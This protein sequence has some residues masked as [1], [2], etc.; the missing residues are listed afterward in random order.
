MFSITEEVSNVF[1]LSHFLVQLVQDLKNRIRYILLNG[2]KM[3]KNLKERSKVDVNGYIDYLRRLK[4]VSECG[5]VDV[6]KAKKALE[7]RL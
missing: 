2:E 3:N 4:D 7:E 1:G 5:S 6:E